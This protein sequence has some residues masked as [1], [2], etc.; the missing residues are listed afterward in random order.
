MANKTLLCFLSFTLFL[1]AFA[2]AELCHPQDKAALLQI[3][4]ELNN[5][6]ILRSWTPTTDCCASWFL[7]ACNQTTNRV[8]FLKVLYSHHVTGRISSAVGDLT[9]LQ[10]LSFSKLPNLTGT[11]PHSITKLRN[12]YYLEISYTG[13]SG[14]VPQFLSQ[15]TSLT[16]LIL[17]G[18]K[19]TG[20]VPPS[21][22]QLTKLES[23]NLDQ[24]ML[25]GTIPDV[26]GSFKNP[27][28]YVT[29]ARNRLTGTVP[30]SFKNANFSTINVS[31]NKLTG[32]ASFL[33]NNQALFEIDLEGNE[34]L[35]D[36]SK[37]KVS[38]NMQRIDISKNKIYGSIPESLTK[39]MGLLALNVSYNE[40]CGKI[41]VGGELQSFNATSYFHNKCLCGAPLPAC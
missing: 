18:N 29:L 23:L 16:D 4:Q 21:F 12:L 3:K 13:I 10:I 33:F 14:P 1:S 28:I 8:W 7:V 34:F 37:V 27:I 36:F 24:N 41:P 2:S 31:K 6:R 30:R 19:F 26:Y 40:L 5:P 17:T 35:F 20:P 11:I 15:M 39:L 22:A 32:D 9:E 38:E 25:T